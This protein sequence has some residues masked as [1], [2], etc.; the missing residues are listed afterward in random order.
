M[1]VV[2]FPI[3]ELSA[4]YGDIILDSVSGNVE[5]V[6]SING[7]EILHEVYSPDI[8]GMV[9]I[10]DVG[11]LAMMYNDIDNISLDNGIDGSCV[12]LDIS[13][14]SGNETFSSPVTIYCCDAETGDTLAVSTLKRMPLSRLTS[15][16][17]GIG[18]TEFISFYGDGQIMADVVFYGDGKDDIKTVEIGNITV[19]DNAYYRFDVSPSVVATLCGIIENDIIQYT[20]YKS[21][22]EPISFI[23]D[24]R[25]Y[26]NKNTFVFKNIFGAQEVFTCTGD[27]ESERKWTRIFGTINRNQRQIS[28]DLVNTIKVNTGLLNRET[29]GLLEDMMNSQHVYCLED[30]VLRKVSIIEESFKVSSRK[31]QVIALEFKYRYSSNNQLQ[32]RANKKR[33]FDFTFDGSFN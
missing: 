18:R 22:N 19:G 17:T 33:I 9:Y 25:S 1:N 24:R 28:R 10:R 3:E 31:D 12:V 26:L 23:V 4:D 16:V 15:K 8:S 14:K 5:A 27:D 30:G 2:R 32:Y 7:S 20:V 21:E 29:L 13:L 11:Y 6:I